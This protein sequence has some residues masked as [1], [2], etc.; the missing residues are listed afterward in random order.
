MFVQTTITTIMKKQVIYILFTLFSFQGFS[1]TLTPEFEFQ[2]YF[3]DAA[4]NKDT[5][6]LGYDS[7]ATNEIDQNFNELDILNQPWSPVFEVRVGNKIYIE[8]DWIRDNSYNSKKQILKE[9]C[10]DILRRSDTVSIQFNIDNLPIALNIVVSTINDSTADCMGL[11][12]FF[13]KNYPTS[14]D[15]YMGATLGAIQYY[16]DFI[17]DYNS[18]GGLS[19][20]I[21]GTETMELKT[22]IDENNREIGVLQF[23]FRG[24]ESLG[25]EENQVLKWSVYPNPATDFITVSINGFDNESFLFQIYSIN[26]SLVRKEQFLKNEIDIRDL[27]DGIYFLEILT[28]D[29]I[30]VKNFKFIKR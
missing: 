12:S 8:D 24:D 1:Q 10:S 28:K 29:R 3:E 16:D 4:G 23:L 18:M 11:S 27:E 9:Y 19:G 30:E 5:V 22:F 25:I 6:T 14:G 2:L 26:G 17:I 21:I 20:Y 7:K 15:A 13:G